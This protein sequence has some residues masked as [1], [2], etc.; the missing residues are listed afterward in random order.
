MSAPAVAAAN[1]TAV[2]LDCLDRLMARELTG[3]EEAAV[4]RTQLSGGMSQMTVVYRRLDAADA[5]QLV[6]RVPPTSGPLDPYDPVVEA[7]LMTTVRGFGIAAPEVVLIEGSGKAI[8][9]AFYVTRFVPGALT[10]EGAFGPAARRDRM[11]DAYMDQL[12]ALH[13]VPVDRPG[14]AGVSLA[15][16]LRAMP[17]KT[18]TAV[19]ERWTDAVE[20]R[21]L[22]IP[23]YHRFLR[24]WLLLRMPHDDGR[25]AV[26]HGDYRLANMLWTES[27]EI[28][29]AMDW[30]EAGLG[31]PYCDLAWTLMG[32]F[33]DDDEVL[34]LAPR[35]AILDRYAARAG[36][37]LDRQRL[38]WWEVASGWSLLG[39]NARAI[40]FIV[41]GT[42]R[43]IRPM[44]YGYLNR[45]IAEGPLRKIEAYESERV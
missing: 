4:S 39:M 27:N 36:I 9:R 15:E 6:V 40:S 24:E 41:D 22:Q 19:L 13:S 18:P 10:A 5:E 45:R 30:E 2:D 38:L 16:L 31:D 8:G 26:V 23:A 29:A 20:G 21:N 1:H 25:R 33:D 32:T 12:A 17:E 7:T 14:A 43:D 44:L 34:G 35:H 11:A 37:E 42:N 28:A 3:D